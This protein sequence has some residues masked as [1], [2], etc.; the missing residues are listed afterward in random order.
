MLRLLLDLG[1][2]V[3]SIWIDG[4]R[5]IHIAILA[6]NEA[7]TKLLLERG[8]NTDFSDLQ[9]N[10]P[11]PL[12]ITRRNQVIVGLLLDKGAAVEALNRQGDRPLH[13]AVAS[14]HQAIVGLLLRRGASLEV[15]DKNGEYPIH[16]AAKAGDPLMKFLLQ[17]GTSV[18]SVT[19]N[20]S[21]T[22]HLAAAM[23]HFETV[24]LLLDIGAD[25]N[26]QNRYNSLLP[27]SEE[28]SSLIP[29]YSPIPVTPL[30]LANI[31]GHKIV[32]DLLKSKG[33][34][35]SVCPQDYGLPQYSISQ[36]STALA[37]YDLLG[38]LSVDA[39]LD[40]QVR[41]LERAAQQEAQEAS[42]RR[43]SGVKC[44]YRQ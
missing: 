44:Q 8:S 37:K 14:G 30:S 38:D 34:H 23:G 25:M 35:Y 13:M 28:Y 33:A 41:S 5:L 40:L 16:L 32:E 22:L 42:R 11:L 31:G 39:Y 27:R 3:N 20:G 15:P 18:K 6:K 10:C 24:K 43:S 19:K 29:G 2:Y 12:A 26:A 36:F 21:I 9:G 1:A 7:I 4:R 17:K